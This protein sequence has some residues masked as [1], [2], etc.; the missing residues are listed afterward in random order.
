[1]YDGPLENQGEA[2]GRAYNLDKKIFLKVSAKQQIWPKYA[3]Y[4]WA[5]PLGRGS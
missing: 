5:C 2:K 4:K 1:M 3:F